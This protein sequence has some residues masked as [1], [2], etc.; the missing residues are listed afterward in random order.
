MGHVVR[1]V[2]GHSVVSGKTKIKV[3][4]D[5]VPEVVP[6]QLRQ[7][8]MATLEAMKESMFAFVVTDRGHKHSSGLS[9]SHFWFQPQQSPSAAG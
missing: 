6:S 7:L 8:T 5:S 3:L 4:Y 1:I 2:A 9:E